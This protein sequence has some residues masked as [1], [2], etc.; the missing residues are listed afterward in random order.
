MVAANMTRVADIAHGQPVQQPVYYKD[1]FVADDTDNHDFRFS[2]RGKSNVLVFIENPAD[3]TLSITVYGGPDVGAEIG[4]TDVKQLGSTLTILTTKTGKINITEPWPY[5]LVRAVF[6]VQGDD[7]VVQLFIN[8]HFTALDEKPAARNLG[9]EE[10][11]IAGTAVGLATIPEGAKSF[12]GVLEL[13]QI[14][15]KLGANPTATAGVPIEIGTSI[16]LNESEL[17][18]MKF[19]RTGAVT[20]KLTGHYYDQDITS[21]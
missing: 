19:I 6:S 14:R 4:D 9:S 2:T 13:S 12:Q 3:Q 8:C 1:T 15:A 21:S 7:S 5:I 10:L 20:G 16:I 11:S 18:G 17:T